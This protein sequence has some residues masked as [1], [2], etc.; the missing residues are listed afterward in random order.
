MKALTPQ[1]LRIGNLIKDKEGNILT[2]YGTSPKDDTDSFIVWYANELGFYIEENEIE[3]IPLTEEWLL[4]F[5]FKKR[6]KTKFRTLVTAYTEL[7]IEIERPDKLKCFLVK[8]E[9]TRDEKTVF[10]VI[11]YVHQLQNLYFALTGDELTIKDPKD[12]NVTFEEVK[13]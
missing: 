2:V 9:H 5:G 1:E 13:K 8:S 4:K 11:R 10:R 12:L 3:P 7:E 6:R